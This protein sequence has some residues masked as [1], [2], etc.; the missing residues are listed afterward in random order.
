MTTNHDFNCH[1]RFKRRLVCFN[2]FTHKANFIVKLSTRF[3]SD[4]KYELLK[5]F[6]EFI[7]LYRNILKI[8]LN[9]RHGFVCGFVECNKCSLNHNANNSN[10]TKLH[11][12]PRIAEEFLQFLK[13]YEKK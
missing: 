9:L 12:I 2:N 3:L 1:N 4:R 8:N 13:N 6:S 11:E 10:S 5:N 7:K